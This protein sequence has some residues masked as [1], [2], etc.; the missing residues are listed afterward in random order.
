MYLV[1]QDSDIKGLDKS[2]PQTKYTRILRS[3]TSFSLMEWDTL[4]TSPI[5]TSRNSTE[6]P[7]N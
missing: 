7:R 6:E 2:M 3:Y 5:S 1:I 4:S